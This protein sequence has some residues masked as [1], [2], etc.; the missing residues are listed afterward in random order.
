ML[1]R[2]AQ[3]LRSHWD[4]VDCEACAEHIDNVIGELDDR[5]DGATILVALTPRECEV[6][7]ERLKRAQ[8]GYISEAGHATMRL[9]E[10]GAVDSSL[11][12]LTSALRGVVVQPGV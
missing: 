8:T 3:A 12:E 2:A 5:E 10:V 1:R 7:I 9:S 4:E 6:I 11:E